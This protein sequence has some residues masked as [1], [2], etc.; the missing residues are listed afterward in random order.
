MSMPTFPTGMNTPT[1]E[2]ALNQVISSIAMEEL[3]LSHIL[4]AEGEKIQFI[5][6]TLE[7]SQL[8]YPASIN[9]ILSIDESVRK[10]LET[11]L[12]KNINLKVKLS[13]TLDALSKLDVDGSAAATRRL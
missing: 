8:E 12:F 7:G 13:E 2:E 3:G 5:L 4:N 6:G 1:L 11:I 10:M 9:D